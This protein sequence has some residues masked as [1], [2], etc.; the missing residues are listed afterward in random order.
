MCAV[1]HIAPSKGERDATTSHTAT[2]I[3]TTPHS[4]YLS[5]EIHLR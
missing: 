4:D 3:P 1:F 5:M 2:A